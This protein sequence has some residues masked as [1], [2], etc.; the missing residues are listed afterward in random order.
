MHRCSNHT[1]SCLQVSASLASESLKVSAYE[2]CGVGNNYWALLVDD[3]YVL[4]DADSAH[5]L[6]ELV[7]VKKH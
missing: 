2:V 6:I 1:H 3:G 5:E 4:V 7:L